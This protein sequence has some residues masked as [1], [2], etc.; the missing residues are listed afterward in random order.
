MEPVCGKHF[1]ECCGDCLACQLH[2]PGVE[3][4][5]D[6]PSW[7]IFLGDVTNPNRPRP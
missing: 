5:R 6:G 4:C 7:T 3:Y 2:E 1:C